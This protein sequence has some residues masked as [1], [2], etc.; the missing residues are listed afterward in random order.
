VS[1]ATL[2]LVRPDDPRALCLCELDDDRDPTVVTSHRAAAT[3]STFKNAPASWAP[4]HVAQRVDGA[5]RND[6]QHAQLGERLMMSSVCPSATGSVPPAPTTHGR[7]GMMAIDAR[8]AARLDRPRPPRPVT[9][10]RG[11]A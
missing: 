5:T 8:V 11:L 1:S 6:E 7:E 4:C 10:D 2:Q 9:R 3:Y